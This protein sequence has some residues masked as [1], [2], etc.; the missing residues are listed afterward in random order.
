MADT[1]TVTKGAL[2]PLKARR[3]WVDAGMIQRTRGTPRTGSAVRL[4]APS[5]EFV[6]W[7]LWAGDRRFPIRLVTWD[8]EAVLDGSYFREVALASA[9]RRARLP[10]QPPTNALRLVF[11]ESD[12]LPGLVVD[13]YGDFAVMKRDTRCLDDYLTA[14]AEA[15]LGEL[16]LS[17]IVLQGE[18]G[19]T[20]LAGVEPPEEV[21][22]REGDLRFGVD[23]RGGQKTGWFCDQRENRQRVAR[24]APDADV[25]DVFCYTGGFAVAALRAGA[26]SVHM[27][28]SSAE[29]LG[30]A[31]G[32]LEMNGL[33]ANWPMD[34]SDAFDRLRSLAKEDR[35]FDL[36]ILDPPKLQ[37]THG[38]ASKAEGA[39]LSLQGL[40]MK[41]LR[42]GGRLAT[43]SCS[44]A[45]TRGRF[46]GV[47][48]R[49]A[50]G[51]PCRILERLGQPADHPILLSHPKSE[52]LTG[53]VVEIGRPGENR[54]PSPS[55]YVEYYG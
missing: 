30:A 18:A 47:V 48:A 40:A 35:C 29:A 43:F 24:Y 32:N 7:G 27:V 13:R 2:Q 10:L 28:D 20:V 15:L 55:R 22:I 31:R 39:Y 44:G 6:A 3:P 42:P 37:P 51:R 25:L 12:G 9:R 26:K 33:N 45:M 11:G 46:D 50:G 19:A 5:G 16:G 1:V 53:L 14:M 41:L 49:A 23:L 36:I 21:I 34:Q 54:R 17:G 8:P 4:V 38:D 52:Y